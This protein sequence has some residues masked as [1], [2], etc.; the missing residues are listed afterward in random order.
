MAMVTVIML[1]VIALA[2]RRTPSSST[3]MLASSTIRVLFTARCPPRIPLRDNHQ[4]RTLVLYCSFSYFVFPL[5]YYLFSIVLLYSVQCTM[6]SVFV[7]SRNV[8]HEGTQLLVLI[9]VI[10]T[11]VK[12]F[13]C[14]LSSPKI[15]PNCRE[16]QFVLRLPLKSVTIE[17]ARTCTL[18]IQ[19]EHVLV[20]FK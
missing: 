3:R 14:N 8:L 11:Q 4:L 16:R 13:M 9:L 5:L 12:S 18:Y 10:P 2:T 1:L 20:H 7:R 15:L 19:I 6:C 17:N